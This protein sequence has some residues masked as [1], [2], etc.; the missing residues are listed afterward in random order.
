MLYLFD[1]DG[2]LVDTGG[3]GIASIQETSHAIFGDKGPELDLAGSTDLGIITYI[4]SH[5]GEETTEETTARFFSLY[6]QRLDWNL[7]H[8]NFGGRVIPGATTLLAELASRPDATLGLLTGNIAGGAAAKMSHFGLDS[9]FPFGAYGCD[10]A[11]RNL[12]GPVALERANAHSGLSFTANETWVIGDTPKDVACAK[13]FGARC[14]A[15]ATGRFSV[16][17]LE[18]CEP[19]RV[20]SS[21][22]EAVGW[23]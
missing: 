22:D 2:T 21:L 20:V 1:I 9:Y 14:L 8:G 6:Q 19:D 11:D 18:A 16:S 5:F 13:A 4:H 23:I 12:L 15:V 17:E 3:A 7:R 10:F